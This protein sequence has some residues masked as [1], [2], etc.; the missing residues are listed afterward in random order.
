M[1]FIDTRGLAERWKCSKR[2]IEQQRQFGEGP[3]FVKIGKQ[4]LYSVDQVCAY[5]AENTFGSTSEHES[6]SAN[7]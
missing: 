5:E 3:A 7:G 2:K 4:V 1:T 6:D